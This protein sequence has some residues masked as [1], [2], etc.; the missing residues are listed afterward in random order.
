MKS[1]IRQSGSSYS[2]QFLELMRKELRTADGSAKALTKRHGVKRTTA[3]GWEKKVLAK[4]PL[5]RKGSPRKMG[6]F[7]ETTYM[8]TLFTQSGFQDPKI[9]TKPASGLIEKMSK[10]SAE[11]NLRRWGIVA[12]AGLRP[13]PSQ[14]DRTLHLWRQSWEQ[15]EETIC[16]DN[17]PLGGTMWLMVTGKGLKGFML[18]VD[19]SDDSVGK[20]A[21][22]ALEK[23]R[24]R[25]RQLRTNH[26]GLA[27]VLK[28]NLP[29]WHV[30]LDRAHS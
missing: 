16:G 7:E 15:P 5:A 14:R 27:S 6:A 29:G 11:R 18:T 2:A 20:V 1:E 4:K 21:K 13:A 25:K 23:L 22:A 3:L 28:D 8:E 30:Q 24:D 26:P 19:E 12:D 10:S 17:P 9:M